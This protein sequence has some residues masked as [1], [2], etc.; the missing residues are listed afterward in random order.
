LT[1]ALC[2]T[3]TPITNA[4]DRYQP[5]IPTF[6]PRRLPHSI[7]FKYGPSRSGPYRTSDIDHQCYSRVS[8]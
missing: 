8:G 3:S 7:R 4:D 5:L 2:R 6:H 1:K